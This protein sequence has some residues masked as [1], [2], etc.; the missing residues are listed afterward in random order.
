MPAPK[1]ILSPSRRHDLRHRCGEVVGVD[2]VIA[3][4][5]VERPDTHPDID[6][7]ANT[8]TVMA[9]KRGD[10]EMLLLCL[11]AREPRFDRQVR[12][13]D[14]AH[15]NCAIEQRDVACDV[16]LPTARQ[17]ANSREETAKDRSVTLINRVARVPRESQND[18][19]FSANATHHG[20]PY[21]R[22]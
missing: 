21:R 18:G 11:Q 6:G 9:P 22:R 16:E 1:E 3:A 17:L 5:I 15:P 2:P 12:D 8:M 19:S 4:A 10:D 14:V 20:G 7:R 13:G